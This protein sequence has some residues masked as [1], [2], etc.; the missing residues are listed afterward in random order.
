MAIY[1]KRLQPL[2]L[3]RA[4]IKLAGLPVRHADIDRELLR[5]YR[6]HGDRDLAFPR[7]IRLLHHL[8]I[9]TGYLLDLD[10]AADEQVH[11]NGVLALE[12]SPGRNH[13]QRARD[14]ADAAGT[15]MPG[16][17]P[18]ADERVGVVK[19]IAIQIRGAEQGV[20]HRF[21]VKISIL[22]V[23]VGEVEFVLEKDQPAAGTRFTVSVV[24]E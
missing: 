13:E 19:V 16:R 10:G 21:L 22:G 1:G 2:Q 18:S 24:A 14:I 7:I 12:V 4:R 9:R 6:I 8:D 23:M 17:P 20:I 11:I 15:C 5:Q 3:R